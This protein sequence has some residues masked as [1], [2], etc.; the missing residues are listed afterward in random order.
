[1]LEFFSKRSCYV[2]LFNLLLTFRNDWSYATSDNERL[3]KLKAKETRTYIPSSNLSTH[4]A[5]TRMLDWLIKI[6]L[7]LAFTV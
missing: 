7:G 3:S 2:V 4:S 1:M 5:K 6:T